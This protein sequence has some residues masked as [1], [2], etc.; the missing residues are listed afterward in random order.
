[1]GTP[2]VQNLEQRKRQ[3]PERARWQ[4]NAQQERKAQHPRDGREERGQ[5]GKDA[6][7]RPME[8]KAYRPEGRLASSASG[9]P[10][11][12]PRAAKAATAEKPREQVRDERSFADRGR[13]KPTPSVR[14]Q[15]WHGK[16][17]RNRA[18]PFEHP[19][20]KSREQVREG[21]SFTD[22][23]RGKPTPSVRVQCW[24]GKACRNRACPFEHPTEK[25]REQVRDVRSY[26]DRG[27]G[28]PAPRVVTQEKTVQWQ[29]AGSRW[30]NR[31]QQGHDP[32]DARQH[33]PGTREAEGVARPPRTPGRFPHV[34]REM[35]SRYLTPSRAPKGPPA[36]TQDLQR[37]RMSVNDN[38]KGPSLQSQSK[39][40]PQRQQQQQQQRAGKRHDSKCPARAGQ[41]CREFAPGGRQFTR[42]AQH[43]QETQVWK[44]AGMAL[45]P[46]TPS[47][48][49][50][51]QHH[52]S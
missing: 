19:T 24:H 48:S 4:G 2:P 37:V 1:M 38:R 5:G 26:A 31:A 11:V 20:E 27:R 44:N 16:A 45:I 49:F 35:V 13:G 30:K 28:K 6:V 12:Q 42:N 29:N 18:C 40:Q 22:G 3:S 15:C 7:K 21:R 50:L 51:Y 41:K 34:E 10:S 46:L 43:T 9:R 23:G 8:G 47:Q 36:S 33:R 14:A 39:S 25:P 32:L 17:C 52:V